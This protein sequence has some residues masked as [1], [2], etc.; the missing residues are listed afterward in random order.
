MFCFEFLL[1]IFL[2]KLWNKYI[3][4]DVSKHMFYT[5]ILKSFRKEGHYFLRDLGAPYGFPP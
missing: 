3:I 5:F 4:I 1:F 2:D